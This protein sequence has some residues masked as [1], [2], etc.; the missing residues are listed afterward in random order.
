MPEFEDAL[1]GELVDAGMQHDFTQAVAFKIRQ[2]RVLLTDAVPD[3]IAAR[4]CQAA[5]TSRA[6]FSAETYSQ[7]ERGRIVGNARRRSL[8]NRTPGLSANPLGAPASPPPPFCIAERA[9]PATAGEQWFS[10]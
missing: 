4:V 5:W 7:A 9:E 10:L 3:D 2:R 8:V 6:A 1:A